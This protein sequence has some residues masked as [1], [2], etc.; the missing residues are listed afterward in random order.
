MT[1][2]LEEE[3]FDTCEVCGAEGGTDREWLW[4]TVYC[5]CRDCFAAAIAGLRP[6]PADSAPAPAARGCRGRRGRL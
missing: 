2:E 5:L 1:E 6:S 3:A 4:G